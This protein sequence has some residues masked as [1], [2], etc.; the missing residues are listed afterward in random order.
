MKGLRD[1]AIRFGRPVLTVVLV[2]LLN[3]SALAGESFTL[4]CGA[5]SNAPNPGLLGSAEASAVATV[6]D[7][8]TMWLPDYIALGIHFSGTTLNI[9]NGGLVRTAGMTF[10]PPT[11][12]IQIGNYTNSGGNLLSIRAGGTLEVTNGTIGYS[13]SAS[14]VAVVT[15]PGSLWRLH[16]SLTIAGPWNSLTLSNSAAISNDFSSYVGYASVTAGNNTVLVTGTN[17][18]WHNGGDFYAGYGGGNNLVTVAG[19]GVIEDNNGYLNGAAGSGSNSIVVTGTNSTWINHSNIITGG[20][21]AYSALVITNGGR[22]FDQFAFL[23]KNCSAMATGRGTIWSNLNDVNLSSAPFSFYNLM[24]ISNGAVVSDANGYMGHPFNSVGNAAIVADTNS[25]WINVASLS[26]GFG[27]AFN[28]LIITNGGLVTDVNGFIGNL[29]NMF[30]VPGFPPPGPVGLNQTIVTGPGSTWSNTASLVVG[31]LISSNQLVITNG[32]LVACSNSMLGFAP[33]SS[34]N[35]ALVTGSN[36][37]GGVSHWAMPANLVVGNGGPGNQLIVSKGA[38]LDNRDGTL[39]ALVTSSNN[40]ALIT[41]SQTLWNVNSNLYVG[42]AGAGNRLV[43]SNNAQVIVTTNATVGAASSSS[44][45]LVLVTDPFSSLAHHGTYFYLGAGGANNW[46]AVSNQGAVA[47]GLGSTHGPA[48]LSIGDQTSSSN[49]T[50]FVTGTNSLLAAGHQV[51]DF[52]IHLGNQGSGNLLVVTNYGQIV[53]TKGLIGD[54]MSAT[55]N[56]ATATAHGEWDIQATGS[57]TSPQTFYVGNNGAQNQLLVT[58]AG[59]V[60][61]SSGASVGSEITSSN[62]TATVTDQGSAWTIQ[63]DLTV[64]DSGPSN[65]LVVV[66]G[67]AVQNVKGTVGNTTFSS[68]NLARVDGIFSVWTNASDLIIG[69]SGGANRLMVSGGADV[70]SFNGYLGAGISSSNNSAVIMNGQSRWNMQSN[71]Y[72]GDSGASNYLLIS[73]SGVINCSSAYV[74]NAVSAQSNLAVVTDLGSAWFIASTVYVGNSGSSNTLVLAN[75]GSVSDDVAEIGLNPSANANSVRVTDLGTIWANTSGV[76]V[77]DKGGGNQ[78]TVTNGGL[79]NC[80]SLTIGANDVISTNNVVVVTGPQS[81]IKAPLVTVGYFGRSNLLLVAGQGKVTT[82]ATDVGASGNVNG[83]SRS[84]QL[85]VMGTG[86]L[87]DNSGNINI[88]NAGVQNALLVSAGGELRDNSANIGLGAGSV[89]NVALVT[90]AGSLWRTTNV[91]NVGNGGSD[92]QLT[93]AAAGQVCDDTANIGFAAGSVSNLALVTDIGS[94]WKTTNNLVVG[95][96]GLGSQ[97]TVAGG[98]LVTSSNGILGLNPSSDYHLAL[99]TDP[100]SAWEI[101]S[102]LYIGNSGSGSELSIENGGTVTD[103]NGCIGCL[104]GADGNAATVDGS[105]ST[106]A[107]SGDVYVGDVGAQSLLTI[108]G[109]GQVNS[110]NGYVGFGAA[111]QGNFA[112]ITGPSSRWTVSGGLYVGYNGTSN[113]LTIDNGGSVTVAQTAIVGLAASG[114]TMTLAVGTLDVVDST[115]HKAQLVVQN[116]S[117]FFV[118]GSLVTDQLLVTNG[119]NSGFNFSGGELDTRQTTVSNTVPFTVGSGTNLAVLNLLGGL[120]SFANGTRISSNAFLTG[121]GTNAGNISCAGTLSP[122]TTNSFG[123]LVLQGGYTQFSN[124]AFHVK[125]GGLA[126]TQFDQ[127]RVT[128]TSTL[129]GALSVV[130]TNGFNPQPGDA[131]TIMTY[132]AHIGTFG[133]LSGLRATNGL[134]LAAQYNPTNLTLVATNDLVLQSVRLA[135]TNISFSFTAASGFTYVVEYTDSLSPPVAWQTLQTIVGDNTVKTVTDPVTVVPH[136]F[137]RVRI[138]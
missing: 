25:I 48:H 63:H 81:E 102:N 78:L 131:L 138:Q 53:S 43:V 73:N 132:A 9:L 133:A 37:L 92:N 61:V 79:V 46:L 116:G 22:V 126:S 49:N 26:I 18:F 71:L 115:S 110:V 65:Q 124:G 72:V 13:G 35:L 96:S 93:V 57:G 74:G 111:S 34:N 7:P 42:N 50:V 109:G 104:A 89:S 77:G 95:V 83:L 51:D 118:N 17:S 56:L 106:W 44:N 123:S 129:A 29:T 33:S 28:L 52:Q 19:G 6:T 31:N 134:L 64:G 121:T 47:V 125:I 130:F 86:A 117:V 88:G 4:C 3:G 97:L 60:M 11:G 114:N 20:G 128:G 85:T 112:H 24:I 45:N 108:S 70:E 1:G 15:D 14:N 68:N 69:Q 16:G 113:Q 137:Y 107:N 67:G 10:P 54:G 119:A 32:G 87:Y 38:L 103:T 120:H 41:D 135:G 39:G 5:V 66:N 36:A 59:V 76:T 21:P 94:L 23:D 84:N 101:R 62:N 8:G 100:N 127:V 136:R 82:S 2:S 55:G 91:L 122:G 90:G 40:A 105:G 80:G 27:G 75:S 30:F 12:L 99:V 98:G 58:N